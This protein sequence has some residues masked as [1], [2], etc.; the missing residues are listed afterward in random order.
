M[1][2][3]LMR[4][5][6][7]YFDSSYAP[8]GLIMIGSLMRHQ[9]DAVVHV[10]CLDDSCLAIMTALL[11]QLPGA[12]LV[13]LADLEAHDP[14]LAAYRTQRVLSRHFHA[15]A[16]CLADYLLKRDPE[17]TDITV[18]HA[19]IYFYASP[20]P[21]FEE[22]GTASVA[23]TP[24]RFSPANFQQIR[25]GAFNTG[26]ITWRNDRNGLRC[27]ADYR[28]DCLG[29][30]D[31][32]FADQL[33]LDQ[34]PQN[35][36]DVAILKHKGLNL[37]LWNVDNYNLRQTA[38]G[39]LV[40]EQPLIFFHYESVELQGPS[41]F[42]APS[43]STFQ[44]SLNSDFLVPGLYQPYLDLLDGTSRQISAATGIDFYGSQPA[45]PA[46]NETAG[47]PTLAAVIA[48]LGLTQPRL[49]RIGD[50]IE[51]TTTDVGDQDVDILIIETVA[52]LPAPLAEAHRITRHFCIIRLPDKSAET[53]AAVRLLLARQG[54]E[55]E[56]AWNEE[57][58]KFL[59]C[60]PF[61][62]TPAPGPS[63]LN[64]GCGGRSHPAWLNVDIAPARATI[65]DWNIRRPLPLPGET[66][67]A[68]Y[69][70]HVLEH[71]PRDEAPSFLSECFR[72][73]KPG[74]VLRI[75]IP[76]LE[77]ICRVY[78]DQLDRSLAG[79]PLADERYDWI[80]L[81]MLDQMVRNRPG[82]AMIDFFRR[83]PLP[84]EEFVLERIGAEGRGLIQALRGSPSRQEADPPA[85]AIGRFRLGGEI[86]QWMYDRFSL[87]RLLTR[88]GF[89]AAQVTTADRS[90]I[91]G[92]GS[93]GLDTEPGG[94][95]R[96]PDSLFMEARRPR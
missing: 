75:A 20:E 27:L 85:E 52:D 92:F 53:E 60:R 58:N 44:V 26:W 15:Y 37:A 68:V 72:L 50:A 31:A 25:R 84:A 38:E 55:I 5:Y 34:W 93:Y 2:F 73:L 62:L 36:P 74:G 14:E 54:F 32:P 18:L 56:F 16:P 81:E 71:L 87:S 35:Y 79:E 63:L 95:V 57:T 48:S 64:I 96:K 19:D 7:T 39:I 46:G 67:D 47:G 70:S 83:D 80:M 77:T 78:L 28:R 21:V 41:R 49:L 3:C 13:P 45:K 90:A 4:H 6:C 59:L 89:E 61:E 33:P 94:A 10:L 1:Q 51:S 76:D 88:A 69:H 66:F 86:H 23:I 9:A 11:P 17:I 82:G 43:F 30:E 40:D 29:S 22:I 42:F 65:F 91:L 12:R 24:H 8:R